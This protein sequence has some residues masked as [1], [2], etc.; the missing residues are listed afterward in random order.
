MI[1]YI[2]RDRKELNNILAIH[3]TQESAKLVF[4]SYIDK[5]DYHYF[6]EL[7]KTMT[8]EHGKITETQ[9]IESH[10]KRLGKTTSHEP[11]ADELRI[12]ISE[13]LRM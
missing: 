12:A 6:L 13:S 11:I 9:I 5:G 1:Y 7:V 4:Q 10:S 3:K 8:C 2:I